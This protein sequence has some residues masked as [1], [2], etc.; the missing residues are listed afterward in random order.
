MSS[1][2][3]FQVLATKIAWRPPVGSEFMAQRSDEIKRLLDELPSGSGWDLGTKL[4][5]DE[6]TPEKLV[7]YGEFHHMN[8]YGM[9]DGWTAHKIIVTPSLQYGFDLR[10]TGR[11]RNQI[12]EYLHEMFDHALRQEVAEWRAESV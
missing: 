8:E 10:I 3:L 7:L 2:Q 11:D 5:E 9:Y 4:D 1:K 12:K 6:S